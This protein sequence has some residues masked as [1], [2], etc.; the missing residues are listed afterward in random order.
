MSET[1]AT[2]H[3][4][5]SKDEFFDYLI[6]QIERMRADDCVYQV[7]LVSLSMHDD[8]CAAISHYTNGPD[9]VLAVKT[10]NE[11]SVRLMMDALALRAKT[12]QH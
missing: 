2:T 8:E 9:E 3:Y 5:S 12:S 1:K 4:N 11:I 10:L 7:W 6:E